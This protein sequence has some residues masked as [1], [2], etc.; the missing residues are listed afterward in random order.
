M[1]AAVCMSCGAPQAPGAPSCHHC[2]APAQHRAPVPGHTVAMD[3]IS[4]LAP[5]HNAMPPTAAMP[6]VPMMAAAPP[7]QSPAGGYQ[8]HQV[9]QGISAVQ[10]DM[11]PAPQPNAAPEGAR[12]NRPNVMTM[13]AG[14]AMGVSQTFNAGFRRPFPGWTAELTEPMGP[15]TGGGKQALQSITI[16]SG[17]G[18]RLTIGRVDPVRRAVTLRNYHMVNSMH[19][20]R[21]SRPLPVS[22]ED[23]DKFLQTVSTFFKAMQFGLTEE[24]Y[25]PPA[26]AL[27][28]AND[29]NR[30]LLIVLFVLMA[31]V[32]GLLVYIY[33][34]R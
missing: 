6:A 34:T 13:M 20:Q 25:V 7:E 33:V 27:T 22:P 11:G 24:R 9:P 26:R 32:V 18:E 5:N 10:L 2:G 16:I 19:A 29:S 17:A 31:A 30:T 28:P 14:T 12:V 3:M 15:S 23:F 8:Q 1:N 21:Y 4:P